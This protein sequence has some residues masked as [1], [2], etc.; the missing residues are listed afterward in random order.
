M[1]ILTCEQRS[2]DSLK[3]IDRLNLTQRA[4]LHVRS[5]L[6]NR[7]KA[8]LA[9]SCNASFRNGLAGAAIIVVTAYVLAKSG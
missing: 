9:P 2:A 8:N 4:R 1:H 5:K 7:V 3:K 6:K